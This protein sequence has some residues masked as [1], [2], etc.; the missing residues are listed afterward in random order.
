MTAHAQKLLRGLAIISVFAVVTPAAVAGPV[1][2]AAQGTV[3]VAD[4][5]TVPALRT[6]TYDGSETVPV[7]GPA[8]LSALAGDDTE[9]WASARS[10]GH[11]KRPVRKVR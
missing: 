7:T 10:V 8:R 11:I 9:A 3:V 4:A 2:A 1:T 6:A 5:T